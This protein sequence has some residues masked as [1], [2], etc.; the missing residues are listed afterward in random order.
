M[1]NIKSGRDI[2]AVSKDAAQ[3]EV[4]FSPGSRFKVTRHGSVDNHLLVYAEEI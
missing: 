4:L 3:E 1:T 2:Q